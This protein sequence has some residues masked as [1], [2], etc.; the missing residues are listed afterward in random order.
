[1]NW[2]LVSKP[3]DLVD[4]VDLVDSVGSV[5]SVDLVTRAPRVEAASSR[6]SHGPAGGRLRSPGHVRRNG[7]GGLEK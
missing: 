3:S 4:L 1:M 2:T 6:F 7:C 5:G